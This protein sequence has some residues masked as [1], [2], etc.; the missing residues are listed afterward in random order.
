[1]RIRCSP[2]AKGIPGDARGRIVFRFLAQLTRSKPWATRC[3]IDIS[4]LGMPLCICSLKQ[5][6]EMAD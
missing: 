6:F 2:V 4:L 3:I 1:M 5:D